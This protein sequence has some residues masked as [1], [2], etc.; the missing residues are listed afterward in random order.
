MLA[1][2]GYNGLDILEPEANNNEIVTGRRKIHAAS[3]DFLATA[4]LLYHNFIIHT[5][6]PV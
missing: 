4:R 5:S 1:R 2:P 6:R 3:R